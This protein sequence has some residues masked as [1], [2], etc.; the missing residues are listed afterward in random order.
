MPVRFHQING[1]TGPPLAPVFRVGAV[2]IADT[3]RFAQGIADGVTPWRR[4]GVTDVSTVVGALQNGPTDR[5][6]GNALNVNTNA[7]QKATYKAVCKPTAAASTANTFQARV[8]IH[9]LAAAT[10]TVRIRRIIVVAQQ[11]AT[12]AYCQAELHRITAVPTGTVVSP[13][14]PTA[15]NSVLPTDGRDSVPEAVVMTSVTA[16]ASAGILSAAFL[17]VLSGTAVVHGGGVLLYDW[18]ESGETK[19]VTLRA[20]VL[21]GIAVGITSNVAISSNLTIEITFTEE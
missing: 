18:Q 10:K 8:T 6:A 2:G 21:E 9:H 5:G 19:P 3:G 20:G 13:T 1:T 4:A 11:P 17:T 15:T 7:V 14:V 12:V 16:A